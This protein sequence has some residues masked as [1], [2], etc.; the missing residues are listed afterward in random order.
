MSHKDSQ[1]VVNIIC[2]TFTNDKLNLGLSE[3][4][5]KSQNGILEKW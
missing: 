2:F 3:N 1:L 5:K 4:G